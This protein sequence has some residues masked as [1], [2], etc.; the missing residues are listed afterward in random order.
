MRGSSRGVVRRFRKLHSRTKRNATLAPGGECA[1]PGLLSQADGKPRVAV[2]ILNHNGAG[3]LPACFES[4]FACDY[5]SFDVV[6]IDNASSD[7]SVPWTL[8]THPS[9][10]IIQNRENMGFAAAYDRAIRCLDYPYLVLLNNDTTVHEMWLTALVAVAQSNGKIAVCGSRILTMHDPTILD[11]GGGLFTW[12]GSGLDV[13][14][15]TRDRGG[16]MNPRETGFACGASLLMGREAYLRVGGFDATYAMYHEDVDLCWRLRIAGYS[17]MHVP[18]SVVYH[19]GGGSH[20]GGIDLHPPRTRFSQKNRLANI[21]K[22]MGPGRAPAAL[23]ISTLYD[24]LRM[25]RLAWAGNKA[26]LK[27]IFGGYAD[28]GASLGD[29]LGKRRIIQ[30]ERLVSGREMKPFLAPLSGSMLAY[31]NILAFQ[32]THSKN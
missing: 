16:S 25:A 28:F 7:D 3:F 13:G 17:I 4:V 29:V 18:A 2:L 30:R 1:F 21:L 12:I 6:L 11:H 27:S 26:V 31:W 32:R 22:N 8:A 5:P 20:G 14:K 10:R 9:V 15:W 19:H 24:L 23:A